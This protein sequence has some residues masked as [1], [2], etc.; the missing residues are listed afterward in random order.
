MF[1]KT[2]N[3]HRRNAA[4]CANGA[5]VDGRERQVRAESDYDHLTIHH[6]TSTP[7]QPATARFK[8]FLQVNPGEYWWVQGSKSRLI[9]GLARKALK[10]L[11]Y[12]NRLGF[13]S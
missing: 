10:F 1:V 13:G 11:S 3:L 9:K 4:S 7:H 12:W 6:F 8:L 5:K 2:T